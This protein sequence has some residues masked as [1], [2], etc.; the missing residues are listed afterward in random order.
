MLKLPFPFVY[1]IKLWQFRPVIYIAKWLDG[2]ILNFK[3]NGT[4]TGRI[5]AAKSLHCSTALILMANTPE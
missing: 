3:V 5:C 2:F 4:I 1:I